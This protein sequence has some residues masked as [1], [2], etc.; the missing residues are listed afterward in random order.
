MAL[1]DLISN[2][3]GKLE[4]TGCSTDSIRVVVSPYRVCPIGAHSDHQLGPTLG[5][6][7]SAYTLLAFSP[8]VSPEVHIVSDNYP[9]EVR[10]DIG[11]PD[12]GRAG[13]DWGVYARGAAHAVK[14]RIPRK[15]RGIR[16]RITG[17][18]PGGGLSSSA[19][20]ILSY[21]LAFAAANDVEVNGRE[22]AELAL[23]AEKEFVG[24]SVGILDPAAIVGSRREHLLSID[25]RE[26]RWK[27]LAIGRTAPGYKILVVFTGTT[28]NLASTG[29]NNR[30]EECFS[31]A[32][33]LASLTG[34]TSA[35]Y[36]G[37][38]EDTE[39]ERFE[40]QL[41]PAEKNRARHFF[42]ER[43]RVLRGGELWQA[44]DLE[45]FGRL[46]FQSCESSIHNYE[47]G[48]PELIELQQI[49]V[50]TPG[51][52]GARFSGAG[53]G[54]CSV[55]LVSAARAEEAR[56]SVEA[57]FRSRFPELAEKARAFLVESE[58]GVRVL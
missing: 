12:E 55:A 33:H 18:L 38:F 25:T 46:M 26:S 53:F 36:L 43:S 7:V 58:D 4:Q 39:F 31:A 1:A 30:V 45:A 21:L 40:D 22:L 20:V 24:V 57:S 16:G 37:D 51:V 11:R 47:T 9:G 35:R 29:Y 14:N 50:E 2:Q 13:D 3:R 28:R 17:T 54:G 5:M 44:G 23:Q 10:F 15:P 52:Y 41:P 6:A 32:G 56:A 19:S 42:G 34:K 8:A 48:S 27:P 49:L